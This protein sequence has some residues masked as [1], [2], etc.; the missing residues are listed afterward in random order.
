MVVLP[1]IKYSQLFINNCWV[2][3]VSGRT[4]P[5]INPATE[6]TIAQVSEADRFSIFLVSNYSSSSRADVNLAVVAAR[7]AFQP[8]SP[9]RSM[10]ASGRGRLL[11]RLADLMTRDREVLAGLDTLDNGKPV[12]DA[13]GDVDQSISTFQ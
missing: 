2:D 4:F 7:A 1:E 5:T 12:E 10:D 9:W 13:R 6:E 8:A 3:S 11:L